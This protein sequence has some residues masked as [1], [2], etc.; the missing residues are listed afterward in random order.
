MLSSQEPTAY[1]FLF[2]TSSVSQPNSSLFLLSQIP[3]A[4]VPLG[5]SF[6]E[7]SSH[8]FPFQYSI[9][10]FQFHIQKAMFLSNRSFSP[11]SAAVLTV[12][13]LHYFSNVLFIVLNQP[14]VSSA[15][16]PR[17]VDILRPHSYAKSAIWLVLVSPQVTP[18]VFSQG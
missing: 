18:N 6:P 9:L 5:N 11:R 12:L 10:T 14:F 8:T 15:V 17:F 13:F 2:L 3:S 4:E 1:G 16:L 7:T